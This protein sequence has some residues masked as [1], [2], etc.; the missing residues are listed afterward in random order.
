MRLYYI[1][2]LLLFLSFSARAQLFIQ[3]GATFSMKGTASLTLQNMNLGVQGTFYPGSGMVMFSGSASSQIYG[4][5]PVQ[6]HRLTINKGSGT[7]HLMRNIEVQ[8][9]LSF[10]SGMLDLYRY[11]LSLA[12]S[13]FLDNERES[14]RAY[15]NDTGVIRRRFSLNTGAAFSPGNLG[16]VLTAGQLKGEATLVRGHQ[17]Q[18]TPGGTPATVRR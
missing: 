8:N 1:L 3:S 17:V 14:S 16:V 5:Q 10:A 4:S 12:N 13:G 18:V 11:E 15:T 9:E 6:F 7:V 2:S